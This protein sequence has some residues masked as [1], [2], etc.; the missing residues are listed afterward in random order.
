M[1]R[2][3]SIVSFMAAISLLTVILLPSTG[4]MWNFIHYASLA[5]NENPLSLT[6]PYEYAMGVYIRQHTD[7]STFIISDPETSIMMAG[8]TGRQIA[9]RIGLNL[10]DMQL[11]DLVKLFFIR[12]DI[13]V[14]DDPQLCVEM[15]MTLSMGQPALILV[16]GRTEKWIN[17]TDFVQ[18]PFNLE[19][20]F[21]FR[22]FLSPPFRLVHEER[23][24]IYAFEV[25][26][27]SHEFGKLTIPIVGNTNRYSNVT[28]TAS[29]LPAALDTW[30][31]W[32]QT[33]SGPVVTYRFDGYQNLGG[34]PPNVKWT[35][36]LPP[37]AKTACVFVLG[38]FPAGLDASFSMSADGK[39]WR[40]YIRSPDLIYV[41]SM[42]VGEGSI[43]FY[44]RGIPAIQ[45][46]L[47]PFVIAVLG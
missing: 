2:K 20:A 42:S 46:V 43:T 38:S 7:P 35:I 18:S 19:E 10:A 13:L 22:K 41:L 44:G 37:G 17:S 45:T 39:E 21:G 12:S 6:E 9:I 33:V 11:A 27:K 5:G 3:A 24:M 26:G 4:P 15:A 14:T 47:G 23:G 32:E 40:Q 36:P 8:L 29:S 25:N 31:P 30:L 16:S 1:G 28:T 34:K